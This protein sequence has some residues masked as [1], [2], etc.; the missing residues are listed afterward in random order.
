M[1]SKTEPVV[2]QVYHSSSDIYEI[3]VYVYTVRAHWMFNT[4]KESFMV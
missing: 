3:T 2:K 4:F 1:F